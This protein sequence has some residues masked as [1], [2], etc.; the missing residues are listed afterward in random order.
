MQA[1]STAVIYA[2]LCPVRFLLKVTIY[3]P[4]G[5]HTQRLTRHNTSG[6]EAGTVL[7]PQVQKLASEPD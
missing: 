7:G 1:H 6:S 5:R 3:I 2:L 4:R